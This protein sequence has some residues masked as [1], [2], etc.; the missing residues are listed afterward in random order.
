MTDITI[1]DEGVYT[2]VASNAV[3]QSS[4]NATIVVHSEP[5]LTIRPDTVVSAR[6]G[7]SLTVECRA[8]GYPEPTV[9]WTMC[10]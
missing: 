5:Q 6:A 7:E 4:A 10:E 2:C 8:K 9:H 3:G 1:N